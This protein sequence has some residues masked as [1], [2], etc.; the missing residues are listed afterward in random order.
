MQDIKQYPTF[1]VIEPI[2][3][4]WS[5]D[6]K[7]YI[8]TKDGN[9]LLLRVADISEYDQKKT[10]FEIMQ[11][12]ATEGIP[13]SKPVDFGVCD[14][15]KNVYSLLTW[16]DGYDAEK[17]LPMLPET[18]QYV[19]GLKA[20][21][22]LRK[23]NSVSTQAMS[24]DWA[25]AY[26]NKIDRYIENYK[27]CGIR[28]E[29]DEMLIDYINANRHLMQNRP[30]SLTHG[31]FH[32]GNL[33]LSPN[34]ELSVIDFNRFKWVDPYHSFGALVF[35]AITSPYFSTGQVRGYFDGEPPKDFW[36]L[37]SLYMAA[38]AVNSLPWS[39]PYGQDEIDFAKRQ[40]T[41]ILSWFNNMQTEV[42][43]WYKKDFN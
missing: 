37:V 12:F 3:K 11:K 9:K 35:S 33:I 2:N 32:A 24:N 16:C 36:S 6:K 14:N 28:F 21:V 15:G 7:Y 43:S 22:I 1:K 8:E 23:I 27:N 5:S 17:L 38:I 10:E 34:K 40:I 19:L 31:D 41:D 26:V 4:G 30:M 13:M 18:E 39:I 20:G 42:P 29:N 25:N